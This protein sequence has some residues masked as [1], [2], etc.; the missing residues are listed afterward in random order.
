[1]GLEVRRVVHP[2]VM[3]TP[4]LGTQER[5][6][7]SIL[8]WVT[9]RV[10]SQI[11]VLLSTGGSEASKRKVSLPGPFQW[12]SHSAG[13]AEDQGSSAPALQV[14]WGHRLAGENGTGHCVSSG[15]SYLTQRGMKSRLPR[16]WGL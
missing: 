8:L 2:A 14:Q 3:R 11:P 10:K 4:S 6:F 5:M 7:P 9:P 16:Q 15:Q 12:A 13:P 1:M